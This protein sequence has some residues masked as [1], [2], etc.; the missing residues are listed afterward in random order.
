MNDPAA[1]L[2]WGPDGLLPVVAQDARTGEVLMVAYCDAG[3]FQ[4]TLES[5]LAHYYSRSRQRRWKKGERSGHEQ[6]VI[7][8]RTDCDHDAILYRVEQEG[9]ACHEGY[10]S[11]FFSR[12]EEGIWQRV[13]TK[14]FDPDKAYGTDHA[15]PPA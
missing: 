7:E 8:V 9:G 15:P 10:R 12:I 11:C 1:A 2:R 13:G 4:A 6:R 3:A 5:G 14:V